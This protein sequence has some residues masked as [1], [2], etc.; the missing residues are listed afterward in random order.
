MPES[1]SHTAPHLL[2]TALGGTIASTAN[3]SGGVA[4]ALS[5]AEIAAAAGLDG[6]WPDLQAD[7]TQVAHRSRARTSPS[8]YSSTS[9]SSPG[10]PPPMVIVL[11][12]GTDTLE[13]SAFGLWLLNDSGIHIAATGAMRNPTLPGSRWAR[14]CPQPPP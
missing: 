13:E 3:A 2:L 7:F 4:P 6:I 11:T 10:P 1:S 9:S 5:G 8:R 14:E 12:Q